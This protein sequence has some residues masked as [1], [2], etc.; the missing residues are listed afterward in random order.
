M[1]TK[2]LITLLAFWLVSISGFATTYYCS[3]K[4]SGDGSSYEKAGSFT[5]MLAKLKAGDVLY[6]LGGQYDFSSTVNIQLSGSAANRICIWAYPGETPIFD[7]RKQA[8]GERGLQVRDGSNYLH[9]KGLTLRYSGKN[10]LHNSGSNNI[11]ELLDVYGNGDT[12]VQMKAGGGNLILNCD[13]HD[14]FDYMLEGDFGGN[15][16]GFADKQYTGGGNTYRGCRAWNNSDDGWDFFQRVSQTG[17]VNVFEDCL[18]YRNGPQDYDMRN[19]GRYET[20][21]SWFDQFKNGKSVTFRDGT[22]RTVTLEHYYNNGN[23]NGFKIG[24]QQTKNNVRLVRCLAVANRVKGFDQ[25]NNAGMMELYNCSAHQN[26]TDYGFHQGECGT[27]VIK[28]CLTMGGSSQVVLRCASVTDDHNSW[29]LS[30]VTCT[31]DDFVSV[32]YNDAV[33]LNDRDAEGNLVETSFLHLVEGSDLIDA[34]VDFGLGYPFAGK[35]PDLGCFEYGQSV[36][37]PG[38]VCTTDNETQNIKQGQAIQPIVLQWRGA[39]T[40]A[41]TTTL[42]DGLSSQTNAD[43]KTLTVSGTPTALGR[44]EFTV[45]TLQEGD[46]TPATVTCTIHVR[47]DMGVEVAYVTIPGSAADVAVLDALRAQFNVTEVNGTQSGN[48]YQDYDLIVISSVPGS[49]A[50][51][52]GELKGISK[53]VLLLKPFMLKNGVW[54]WGTAANTSDAAMRITDTTHPV[55]ADVTIDASGQAVFFSSVSTNAVTY[56]SAWSNAGTVIQ[57][58]QPVSKDGESIFLLPAGQSY[59]GTT[60]SYPLLCVGL[61]EYSMANVTTDALRVLTNAYR[62]QHPF[63]AS[64]RP[65]SHLRPPRPPGLTSHLSPLTS[66]ARSLHHQR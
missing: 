24:G 56:I 19:H 7:F 50:A 39:A 66:K 43:A 44:H 13:S 21:K 34:G 3:P 65:H 62:H 17:T 46:V 59:N 27:L 32:T 58:A 10:A 36:N 33:L 57:L 49:N 26:G 25:N 14:N 29:S 18:C 4:G 22:T 23:G 63:R 1:T 2:K 6:C 11:F 61:S 28:N 55:F 47:E 15:A 35:A 51:G 40:G 16:D 64:R 48:N 38:L 8:Y 45:S 31:Q 9:I 37:H 41:V 60:L 12:G 30:G 52:M 42:P 54:S 20:D 53:P 5:A